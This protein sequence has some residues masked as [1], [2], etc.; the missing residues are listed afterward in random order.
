MILFSI[1]NLS[2][3]EIATMRQALNVIDIKGSS[4]QFVA[5]LQ[6]KLDHEIGSA[7]AILKREEVKK[8][9]GIEQIEKQTAKS[10]KAK[11]PE[12]GK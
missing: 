7:Q 9:K 12:A 3:E 1:K 2:I 4:A 5:S 8:Q 11:R 6:Q 10:P